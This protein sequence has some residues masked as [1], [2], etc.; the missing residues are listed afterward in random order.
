MKMPFEMVH[1]AEAQALGRMLHDAVQ[2]VTCDGMIPM[3]CGVDSDMQPTANV[4]DARYLVL[5]FPMPTGA[6]A[7][8][9][10]KV[11]AAGLMTQVG[12]K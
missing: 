6:M 1:G 7:I 5:Q 2:D 3:L 12:S 4:N 10:V 8:G 11:S 9:V